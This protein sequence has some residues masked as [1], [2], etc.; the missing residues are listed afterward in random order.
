MK[1]SEK[2]RLVKNIPMPIQD[3]DETKGYI[4]GVF[5]HFGSLDKHG[6][7][8][9]K[10]AF[11]KT[12]LEHGPKG[13]NEI[14]HLLDHKGDNAVAAIT[15]LDEVGNNLEYTSFIGTHDQGRNFREMVKSGIIKFHSIGYSTVKQFY[16]NQQKANL[17]QE[18][19][20][21]EGSS[22]QFIAANHNTPV[23]GMKS[24]EQMDQEEIMDYLYLLEKFVR[25]T[26][27][28]DD[29]IIEIEKRIKSLSELIEAGKPTLKSEKAD[30]TQIKSL[31][32][33][34]KI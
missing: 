27:A 24:F 29:C 6:D 16:D 19:K 30:D 17:L 7:I 12:I 4:R 11:K 3:M 28:T 22:L 10:G 32:D 25:N 8:I 34:L 2:P 13:T 31:I 26:N 5:A 20:L 18:L 9:Q 1:I 33:L 23:L 21:W 14:A 15:E